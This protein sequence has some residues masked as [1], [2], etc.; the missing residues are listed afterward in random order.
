M[1]SYFEDLE[2]GD[3]WTGGEYEVT[4]AEI[5][6]FAD[7]YDPQWFHTNPE[8]AAEQ[9]MYGGL[10]ASGW[11]TAAMSM[12]LL[13][14]CFLSEAATLGAKGVDELRWHKPVQPSDR[15]S[16]RAAVEEKTVDSDRRGTIRLRVE[17]T[18]QDDELVFSMVGLV[19][20]ARQ[21]A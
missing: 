12:R 13:V 9:S 16:V 7:Q 15:L 6:E 4:E 1:S 8:R 14:D 17:T 3:E 18:N 10:I 21:S 20:I 19:M 11:H 2:T 5:I